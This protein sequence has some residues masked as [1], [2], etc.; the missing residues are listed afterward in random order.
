M[1]KI[2]KIIKIPKIPQNRQKQV[3]TG[4]NRSKWGFWGQKGAKRGHYESLLCVHL[5]KN[6]K[7]W[8]VLNVYVEKNN[9]CLIY[10]NLI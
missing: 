7:K 5:T 1:V 6:M 8:L 10:V 9:H 4:K 3:K 2:P